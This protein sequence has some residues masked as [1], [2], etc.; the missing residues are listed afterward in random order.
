[1][2]IPPESYVW[3]RALRLFAAYSFLPWPQLAS[4]V[5]SEF[6]S[7]KRFFTWNTD[8]SEAHIRAR[9]LSHEDRNLANIINEIYFQYISQQGLQVKRW[10]EKTPINTLYIEKIQRVFPKAK[11]L[12]IVRDPRDVVCSYIKAGFY[13]DKSDALSRWEESIK[14]AHWLKRNLSPT[15]YHEVRYEDLVSNP[16]RELQQICSFLDLT[17]KAEMLSFKNARALGD[18]AVE[19][20]H[21]NIQRPLTTDSIGKWK[22]MLLPEEATAIEKRAG[23]YMAQYGYL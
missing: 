10:G 22:K 13:T 16:E 4:M 15:Q 20:H 7:Y 8:L 9:A 2:A 1:M 11:Y 18:V 3:P 5:I 23:V 6:S 21:R 14:K 12:H 19:E 17:F